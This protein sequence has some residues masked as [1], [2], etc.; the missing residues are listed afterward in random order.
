MQSQQVDQRLIRRGDRLRQGGHDRPAREHLQQVV[1]R[2]VEA[3]RQAR[4]AGDLLARVVV[5]AAL[6]VAG[7]DARGAAG[8]RDGDMTAM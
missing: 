7:I 5:V 4:Q 8:A 2:R 1:V 6:L 3:Q